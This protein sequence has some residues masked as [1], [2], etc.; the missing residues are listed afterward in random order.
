MQLPTLNM[1][2]GCLCK[3][4]MTNSVLTCNYTNQKKEVIGAQNLLVTPY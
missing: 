2:G 3:N 1:I 4:L